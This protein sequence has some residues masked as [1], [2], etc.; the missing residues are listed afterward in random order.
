MFQISGNNNFMPAQAPINWNFPIPPE[1]QKIALE[2]AVLQKHTPSTYNWRSRY[3]P[4]PNSLRNVYVAQTHQFPFDPA[5]N[6]IITP[7]GNIPRT[8]APFR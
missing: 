8:P 2:N 6:F 1:P 7:V 5:S 3:A 4:P